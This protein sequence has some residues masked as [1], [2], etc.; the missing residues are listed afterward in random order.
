MSFREEEVRQVVREKLRHQ[1]S[2]DDILVRWTKEMKL[3]SNECI[4]E[5]EKDV[6]KKDYMY[7][8]FNMMFNLIGEPK[9]DDDCDSLN[10]FLDLF[11]TTTTTGRKVNI[12]IH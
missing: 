8:T 12:E 2:V 7:A 3:I 6:V 11:L 1:K 10:T 4:T 9:N 5:E